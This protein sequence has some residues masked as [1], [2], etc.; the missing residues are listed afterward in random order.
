LTPDDPSKYTLEFQAEG[1]LAA[2]IDCNRGSGTWKSDEPNQLELGPLALT[3]MACPRSPLSE[4]MVKD[5]SY[6]RS[7]V[8]K[9]GHLYV[10]LMA[11][12]G[13]YEFEPL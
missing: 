11:D 10:A 7:Y 12:G 5:W 6:V 9:D 2:R 13:I 1:K 3:H 8:L 4:R